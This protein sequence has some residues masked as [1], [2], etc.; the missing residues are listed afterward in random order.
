MIFRMCGGL[1]ASDGIKR[2]ARPEHAAP[3]CQRLE[4]GGLLLWVVISTVF[5]VS[6]DFG[7]W[8]RAMASRGRPVHITPPPTA[9]S[10]RSSG[11]GSDR[12]DEASPEDR[13]PDEAS[14]GDARHG[15]VDQSTDRA[16][17]GGETMDRS[18]DGGETWEGEDMVPRAEVERMRRDFEV[19]RIPLLYDSPPLLIARPRK[20]DGCVGLVVHSNQPHSGGGAATF[21]GGW[22]D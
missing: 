16:I 21:A 13:R 2:A 8:Q 19:R 7:A 11:S 22:P 9:K 1:A 17:N 15:G 12:P 14:P 5:G 10:G 6:S 20:I 3:H 4:R 18:V